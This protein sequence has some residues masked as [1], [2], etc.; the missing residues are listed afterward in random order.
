MRIS[1]SR[2]GAA[3]AEGYYDFPVPMIEADYVTD[4]AGTGF[5]HT[6]PGHGREDFDI[7]MANGRAL[8]EKS[9]QREGKT[10]GQPKGNDN[11]T[12]D[13]RLFEA[14]QDERER[15][16][17]D[18]KV[19]ELLPNCFHQTLRQANRVS[20]KRPSTTTGMNRIT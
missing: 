18:G 19:E 16:L 6:A 12:N 13:D 11:K 8:V 10:A 9:L 1:P 4:N 5:V 17:H 15:L 14:R 2:G 7:W 20:R 3:G